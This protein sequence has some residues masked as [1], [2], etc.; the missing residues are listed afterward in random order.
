M[1]EHDRDLNV[2][3]WREWVKRYSAG[4][5]PE[6]AADFLAS[7]TGWALH[8]Q[9]GV[10][11]DATRLRGEAPKVRPLTAGIVLSRL[12]H[13]HAIARI[14]TVAADHLGNVQR[15]V[16]TKAGIEHATRIG[17]QA[18]HDCGL[19]SL[20][21][22]NAFNIIFRRSFLAELYKNIDLHPIIPLVEMIYSRDSTVYY[23]DPNDAS[24]LH[25]TAQSCTGVRQGDPLGPLLFNLAISTPFRNIG[26]WCKDSAAIQ[27]FSDDGKYL[28]K[29]PFV[30]TVITVATEEMGTVCSNQSST[31]Q[32]FVHGTSG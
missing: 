29:T 7:A 3:A 17:L 6:A 24:L 11:R 8:K 1:R 21:M 12:A 20:D 25:G 4:N 31:N 19:L 14:A 26:E 2:P 16:F 10:D 30:P 27:A 23:F 18:I 32:V 15:S 22:E 13:C 5:I 9:T 28:I